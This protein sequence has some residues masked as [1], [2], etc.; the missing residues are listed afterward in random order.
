MACNDDADSF[1]VEEPGEGIAL[2]ELPYGPGALAPYISENT[3]SFHYGKHH[4]GY[5]NKT[6]EI[7]AGTEFENASLEEIIKRTAGKTEWAALFNNAAQVFNHNFYWKSMKQGGGGRPGGR[8]AEKIRQSFGD[9]EKFAGEFAGAAAAQ[10]GSGWAW[11]VQ[12]GGALKIVKTSNADTPLEKGMKPLITIDVWEHAYY[13]D[14]Q[15][16]RSDYIKA[17]VDSLINWEFAERNLA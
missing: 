1:A 2:P 15:N 11:L 7:V 3:M 13:L 5:V 16:L 4:R 17:F 12:D 14:Y 10:F 6:K 8:I 9:Y